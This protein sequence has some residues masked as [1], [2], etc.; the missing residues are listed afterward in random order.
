LGGSEQFRRPR[1]AANGHLDGG[2]VMSCLENEQG[3]KNQRSGI[4]ATCHHNISM[5][6]SISIFTLQEMSDCVAS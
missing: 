6:T 5:Q 4:N 3:K 1:C 2:F